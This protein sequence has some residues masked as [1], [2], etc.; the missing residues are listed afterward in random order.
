MIVLSSVDAVREA[1]VTKQND[2]AGRLQTF[3]CKLLYS[4][5]IDFDDAYLHLSFII[6]F[7]FNVQPK[8]FYSKTLGSVHINGQCTCKTIKPIIITLYFGF[9]FW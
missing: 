5:I 6:F 4:I 3:S 1:F 8:T 2:F 7:F 9:G